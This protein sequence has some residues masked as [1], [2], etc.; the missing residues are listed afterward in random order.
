MH[1]PTAN[2]KDS[3]LF[4]KD[5]YVFFDRDLSWLS[6]NERVLLEAGKDEVPLLERIKF[7]SIYSSNS[8]EFYRV[9]MPALMALQKL[10]KKSKA[11]PAFSILQQASAIIHRQQERFG[12]ILGNIIP[13]L[14]QQ[15]NSHLVYK[16]PIPA[17]VAAAA[18]DYF[19]T[20]VLAFL[21]PVYL[22]DRTAS[23]FPENNKLY[24]VAI[25]TGKNNNEEYIVVN[26]PSDT[27]PR[28]YSV[29]H[30]DR[31]YLLFLDDIIR[32]NLQQVLPHLAIQSS[33]SFKVTRDAELGIEDEYEGDIA[34]KIEKQ[35]AKRDFG[36]A[37]R[38]LY[39]AGMPANC[40]QRLA[41]LLNLENASLVQGGVYHNLKDLAT[42]PVNNPQLSYPK[43]P[44]IPYPL[45]GMYDSLLD[46]VAAQD[47]M[48]HPPY[49]SYDTVLRFFNEAAIHPQVEEIYVTLYR[50]A[51]DSKIAHALISAA[52]NG[53]KVTVFVELKARFDEANNI[54][55][56]KLMKAAGV[57]II[58][59][60][61]TLK[62][63]AKVALIKKVHQNRVHYYGLLA[64]GNLNESTARFYTDH[65][66][67]TAN[68]DMLRELES[69]FVFLSERKK[70]AVPG[71][72]PFDHLLI[73]QFNLQQQFIAFINREIT[74]AR[75]GL[76]A[77][78]IIKLNNL[79]EKVMI[80]KLYEAST[81]GV[82]VTL[83]VRSICCL[84]PGVKGM[85]EHITVRRIVDK[86]LE[87]GRVF[88]FHNN[89][90][91]TVWMGS[92]DWM[93]RNIYRRIEV[94]FPV[95]DPAI[96][97]E[98]LDIVQLQLQ[99]TTQAVLLDGLLHNVPVESTEPPLRS[100][101]AIH[102]LLSQ[103]K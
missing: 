45:T 91:P 97:K 65:I 6:F 33:Y 20:Q 68:P 16:E 94:C 66:L 98:I 41:G 85:S 19:F 101:E 73:A 2:K 50:I 21:Q 69:L 40:F 15:N 61:P 79:E 96:K 4:D 5:Q 24:L 63:H 70:P 14:L 103:G 100:Q 83:I 102:R 74:N 99:D 39:G 89:N 90:Q 13:L 77:G 10:N 76:P 62:V 92:A 58:Y 3:Q 52:K 9:R 8:D 37:T 32:H 42:L 56:S 11:S 28:F 29:H 23:F 38:F 67:L 47:L 7:L 82:P 80:A 60:I 53:K 59:S 1:K 57:R 93:N 78:I 84:V 49:Q 71:L 86:Y 34:E 64:T 12:A 27:L 22:T 81:A 43:W 75:Q 36:F 88:I 95:N 44:A 26:I 72:L 51:S 25:A 31:Q 30:D 46:R 35:I 17:A 55:W 18:S 87:H 54:R 48:L